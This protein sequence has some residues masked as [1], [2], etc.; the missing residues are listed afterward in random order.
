MKRYLHPII[1]WSTHDVWGLIRS[2][3][4]PYC[5]L[6]DE[7]FDRVGCIL[8]PMQSLKRRYRDLSRW[9]RYEPAFRLAFRRLHALR[10]AQGNRSVDRWSDGDRMFDWWMSGLPVEPGESFRFD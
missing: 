4:L 6:Y 8:C 10:V 9:P 3:G 1:D 2:E 7:G 5:S